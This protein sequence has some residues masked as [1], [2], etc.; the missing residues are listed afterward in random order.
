MK[1]P[2]YFMV[3]DVEAIGLHGEGF[4]FG[5]VVISTEHGDRVAEARASCSP[6]AAKGD[7]AGVAW[8]IANVPPMNATHTC[9]QALRSSFW[10]RQRDWAVRGGVLVADVGWPVEANFLAACI[11]DAP[12]DRAWDGPYPLHELASIALALGANVDELWAE[13]QPDELP[14][15]DPLNDARHSARILAQLLKLRRQ[16][17]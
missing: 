9:P 8:V 2:P 17:A 14:A 11:A 5:F 3:F 15:H 13:R 12:D 4:A 6:M 7:A 1:L 16:A 10:R